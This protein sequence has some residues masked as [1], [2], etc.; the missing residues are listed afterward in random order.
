[1]TLGQALD[2]EIQKKR[3]TQQEAADALQ[4]HRT[5]LNMLLN[6]KLRCSPRMAVR[7]ERVFGVAAEDWLRVQAQGDVE[8]ARR[9]YR[10]TRPKKVRSL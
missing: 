4:T 2:R 6:G 7:L 3:W 1:M 9:Y 8:A 10:F 5:N